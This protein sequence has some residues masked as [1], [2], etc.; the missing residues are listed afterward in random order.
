M[1]P[2][3]NNM[4]ER[5]E[6]NDNES[7]QNKQKSEMDYGALSYIEAMAEVIFALFQYIEL[8]KLSS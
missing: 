2:W 4:E 1:L 3:I 6:Q 8:F 5:R 7:I